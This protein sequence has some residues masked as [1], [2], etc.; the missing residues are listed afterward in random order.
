MKNLTKILT[1]WPYSIIHDA[2][3]ARAFEASSNARHSAVKRAL[4]A[5]TLTRLRRGVYLIVA[6][7]KIQLADERVLA[8]YIYEPSFISLET[9]LSC[10]GWIPEAVPVCTS[11]TPNRA[12]QFSTPLGTFT[13]KHVPEKAFYL[14]VERTVLPAGICFIAQPWRAVADY[15]YVYAKTWSSLADFEED[16]RIDHQI[17]IASSRAQLKELAS[18]Y[19]SMRVRKMLNIF[20]SEIV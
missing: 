20:L 11:V 5:S 2:E 15:V 16:M 13:Y 7:T 10:H 3:I 14:G 4:K 9:A 19:P 12:Q 8:L 17:V 6:K 1:D 18:N